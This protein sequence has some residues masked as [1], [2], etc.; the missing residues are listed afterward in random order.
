MILFHPAESDLGL[1]PLAIAFVGMPMAL[2]LTLPALIAG[3]TAR[4]G[5]APDL[6]A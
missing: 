2:L 3:I 4:R 5:W 6:I 1:V